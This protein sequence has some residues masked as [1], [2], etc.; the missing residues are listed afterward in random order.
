MTRSQA[1]RLTLELGWLAL[2]TTAFLTMAVQS[3]GAW[4]I[5]WTVLLLGNAVVVGRR[6]RSIARESP[7]R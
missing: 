2:S 7:T 4:R 3:S 5:A 1:V 6:A